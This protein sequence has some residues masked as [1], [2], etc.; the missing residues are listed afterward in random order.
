VLQGR[1]WCGAA[2]EQPSRTQGRDRCSRREL[3]HLCQPRQGPDPPQTPAISGGICSVAV[4][5]VQKR[6]KST[7]VP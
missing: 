4:T 7:V 1:V 6:L 2:D 3:Y 5:S